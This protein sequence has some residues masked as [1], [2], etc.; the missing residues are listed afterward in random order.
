MNKYF[1]NESI[2]IL[3]Y[4]FLSTKKPIYVYNILLRYFYFYFLHEKLT[5]K[6]DIKLDI[7]PSVQD[8]NNWYVRLISEEKIESVLSV[9]NS[10]HWIPLCGVDHT[11]YYSIDIES[12]TE[13]FRHFSL[14]PWYDWG[15][16][17]T[18]LEVGSGFGIYV[19]LFNLF[20]KYYGYNDLQI[21]SFDFDTYKIEKLKSL[22][23]FLNL[24]DKNDFVIG[25]CSKKE[26]FKFLKRKP[27]KL[28]YSETFSGKGAHTQDYFKIMNNVFSNFS[29]SIRPEAIFPYQFIINGQ[30]FSAKEY[31]DYVNS[32]N[33]DDYLNH[34]IDAFKINGKYQYLTGYE[35]DAETAEIKEYIKS[36]FKNRIGFRWGINIV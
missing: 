28:F 18:V 26:T 7:K 29:K 25:D 8:F 36:R 6:L 5:N 2:A 4:E 31:V 32:S 15:I 12:N 22:Y 19:F 9:I 17:G 14:L 20:K 10:E 11:F 23:K 27:I 35:I 34:F 33:N 3:M 16:G 1:V 13:L 24:T 30:E 21:Y